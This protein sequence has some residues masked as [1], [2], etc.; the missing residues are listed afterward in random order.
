MSRTKKITLTAM[1]VSLSITINLFMKMM[2]FLQLGEGGTFFSLTAL[3][4]IYAGLALGPVWGVFAG[5]C[6][7]LLDFILDGAAYGILSLIFDYVLAFG[8]LGLVGLFKKQFKEGKNWIVIIA[9][10][11]F[12]LVRLFS[13]TLSSILVFGATFGY[14]FITYNGPVILSSTAAVIIVYLLTQKKIAN[15]LNNHSY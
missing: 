8:V 6:Y 15:Y 3:P 7:G 11:A 10:V 1:M 9:I 4:I 14:G 5:V 13:H 12:E 2:P